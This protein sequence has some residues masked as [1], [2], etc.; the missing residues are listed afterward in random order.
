[1][2]SLAWLGAVLGPHTSPWLGVVPG[3]GRI[4]CLAWL[5]VV[6]GLMRRPGLAWC[7]VLVGF[8]VW[9]ELGA[10]PGP[11]FVGWVGCGVRISARA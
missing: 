4:R 9:T 2:R 7:P 8:D 1:M 6:L 3:P 5:G 10:A 11:G